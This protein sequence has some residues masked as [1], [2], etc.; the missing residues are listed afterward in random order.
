MNTNETPVCT[1]Q[2]RIPELD[3]RHED[4]STVQV[5]EYVCEHCGKT[6][7]EWQKDSK[8]NEK[9]H[10]RFCSRSCSHARKVSKTTKEKI[11][12][13]VKKFT[14]SA[15]FHCQFCKRPCKNENSLRNHERLCRLNPNGEK[16]NGNGGRMPLHTRHDYTRQ[17]SLGHGRKLNVTREFIDK[18]KLAH[19]HC[20]ICG[21]TVEEAT[22]TK[23]KFG[24][25]S[26]CIDHDHQTMKFRG[27]LC[28]VCNRQLG[29]FE[30]NKEAI[31]SYLNKV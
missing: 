16:S 31:L 26:L 28:S 20:E 13:G 3:S 18:Y 7:V 29:W 27:L 5:Q 6:F 14:N 15:I 25:H 12:S 30:K 21:R 1:H 8:T 10:P 2:L 22:K 4:D 17:F 24:P 11:S 19:K 9:C 23:S